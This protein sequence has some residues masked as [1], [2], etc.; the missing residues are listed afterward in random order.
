MPNLR[1]RKSNILASS[2]YSEPNKVSAVTRVDMKFSRSMI[3]RPMLYA[4]DK[5][6]TRMRS[7]HRHDAN[8]YAWHTSAT[9]RNLIACENGRENDNGS[10]DLRDVMT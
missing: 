1:I 5:L 4:I 10:F 9:P 6:S 8:N 7:N 3:A 2:K